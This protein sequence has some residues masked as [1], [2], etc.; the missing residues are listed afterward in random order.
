MASSGAS[1]EYHAH[2]IEGGSSNTAALPKSLMMMRSPLGSTTS[3]YDFVKVQQPH[4]T[5]FT[6]SFQSSQIDSNVGKAHP[7][8]HK[9]IS[10]LTN[11]FESSQAHP[12]LHKLIQ[13]FTRW[14]PSSQTDPNL[15]KLIRILISWSQSSQVHCKL[16][17]FI[18][19]NLHKLCI[20]IFT[21]W[22]PCSQA[23]SNLHNW[24][25]SPN[26]QK[27]IPPIFTSSI[28]CFTSWFLAAIFTIPTGFSFL[29]IGG[30]R[31][32]N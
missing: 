19:F 13:I 28:Q 27:L 2:E 12:H 17:Q 21:R 18:S 24:T 1:S 23:D 29:W 14:S 4:S 11:W 16:L 7:H 32:S 9:L 26:P 3:M 15:H 8:L 22:S 10:I 30:G 31:D 6:S 25:D 5:I 20:P